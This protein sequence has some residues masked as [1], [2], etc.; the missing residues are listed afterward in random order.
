[1]AHDP[2]FPART[3]IAVY[4]I[5]LTNLAQVR[6]VV[7]GGGRVATRK[8]AG[9]LAAG[10]QLTLISPDLT[11]D[12]AEHH[13]QGEITWLPRA[14]QPGDL[15]GF[16]LAFAATN[17]PH[18]NAQ[19]AQEAAALGILCNVADAPQAGSFHLPA[20]LRRPGLVVAVGSGGT[21]PAR[22]AHT[23]DRIAALLDDDA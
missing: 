14:Y 1:M 18:V 12:L 17:Q 6:A 9:L 21:D 23:R 7:I 16:G 3:E 22:A 20:V 13:R 8:V 11:A 19:I 4:P 10:I 15:A 2:G 5:F